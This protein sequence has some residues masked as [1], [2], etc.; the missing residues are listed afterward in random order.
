MVLNKIVGFFKRLAD[1]KTGRF[2]VSGP[3]CPVA[4]VT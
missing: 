3:L 1:K 4:Q 2:L